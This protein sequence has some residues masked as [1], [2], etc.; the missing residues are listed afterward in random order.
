MHFNNRLINCKTE[1]SAGNT[2]LYFISSFN[3]RYL[4]KSIGISFLIT[5]NSKQT[6]LAFIFCMVYV[7]AISQSDFDSLK[8]NSMLDSSFQPSQ[9]PTFVT[10]YAELKISGFLQPALYLDNNI[11]LNNDLFITSQIPT[12][13]ITDVR[14]NRF[15]LSANQSRLSF[16]FKFPKAGKNISAFIEG[17]FIQ[18]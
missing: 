16:G 5:A 4:K 18:Q 8:R 3:Y 2:L 10:E 6:C 9:K 11:L 14:F 15:H 1:K 17:L 13:K 12:T 7:H